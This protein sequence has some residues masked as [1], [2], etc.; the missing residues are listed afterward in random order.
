MGRERRFTWFEAAGYRDG[1][2]RAPTPEELYSLWQQDR[3]GDPRRPNIDT[4]AFPDVPMNARSDFWTTEPRNCVGDARQGCGLTVDFMTHAAD[5][6]WPNIQKHTRLPLLV[7]RP[8]R[9]A[10]PAEPNSETTERPTMSA[11]RR[12]RLRGGEAEDTRTKLVWQRCPASTTYSASRGCVGVMRSY[13]LS[14]ARELGGDGWRLPTK[15]E[16]L[17][18]VVNRS[19][20]PPLKINQTVFYMGKLSQQFWTST[21]YSGSHG[22]QV[23]CIDFD[24]GNGTN[25][26]EYPRMVRLVRSR[27]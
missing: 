23:W 15:D 3:S 24:F 11:D 4:A 7:V 14:D 17:T 27:S 21:I 1:D 20:G 16:L 9:S 22:K 18:L 26:G 6:I 5:V 19:G 10:D 8:G 2:W 25:C 13:T 12:F